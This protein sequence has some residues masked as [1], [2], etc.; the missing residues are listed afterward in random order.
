MTRGLSSAGP[1]GGPDVLALALLEVICGLHC[2]IALGN[3]EST[4]GSECWCER[5]S[6]E[7][8]RGRS[9]GPTLWGRE[10]KMRSR[11]VRIRAKDAKQACRLVRTR[12]NA[13]KQ[14]CED[15]SMRRSRYTNFDW[16]GYFPGG[17]NYETQGS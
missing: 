2:S 6:T 14:A 10:Q 16:L 13:A 1:C 17:L 15:A 3:S 7:E 9:A 12:T 11:L 4:G 8:A 5:P